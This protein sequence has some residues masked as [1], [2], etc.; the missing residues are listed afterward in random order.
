MSDNDFIDPNWRGKYPSLTAYYDDNYPDTYYEFDP[1]EYQIDPMETLE[2]IDA[3]SKE[4]QEREII[5]CAHSFNYFCHKYVKITHPKRGLLPFIT[6]KYQRRTVEDYNKNRFCIIRKFRQGGLT[7]VTVLWALWRCLFKLDETI[8]VVS[9]TDREAIASG[10]I[11]KR[12][13]DEL[14]E[15]L[16]PQMSKNNDHQK[17]FTET[18]CKLFFYPPEAARGRSITYLVIDEA[19]FVPGMDEFWNAIL[20]TV[21]TG[22][23]V[24]VVSTVNGVGNW[25]HETYIAAERGEND[26]HIINLE[27]TEHPDY[28]NPEWVSLIRA[29]LGEQGWMQEIIGDFLGAGDQFIPPNILND[30]DLE[31]KDIEPIRQLFPD[32]TNKVKRSRGGLNEIEHGALYI[33]REPVDGR[34]YIIG[35]DASEGQGG[36]GDNSCAQVIDAVTCEQVGEFYSNSVPN[37]VFAQIVAQL[38]V[39]Y[40]NALVV[41]ESEKCGLTILN[42]LQF[43]LGYDNLY[44]EMKGTQTKPGI[45]T[46]QSTRPALLE[47]LR[48]RMLTRSMVV[49][50]RRLV[51]EL[52]HFIFNKTTRRPEHAKGYHDDAIFAIALALYARESQFR[53]TPVGPG[54]DV[55]DEMTERYRT[56]IY[57]QIKNE[58]L[59]GSTED[60]YESN[61]DDESVF[62]YTSELSDDNEAL[63][64]YMSRPYHSLLQEFGW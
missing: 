63:R 50:S 29:Q 35:V 10:E 61:E 36:E 58:L 52:K 39:M 13:I 37:H 57:E 60:W 15:W 17:I 4:R 25:Y 12:A 1:L 20:P 62:G 33:W 2:S 51:N 5:K 28:N 41:V 53:H 38:G 6:F 59:K 9:K 19:A 23:N 26:F 8:M 32:W 34:D 55:P 44:Y 48:T 46:T 43:H 47:G 27:Y 14:P 56:N 54:V 45:K 3:Y 11:V 42:D 31:T 49:R 21:A 40:N 24:I 30:M 18:G 64:A 22:G 7:T 16:Q